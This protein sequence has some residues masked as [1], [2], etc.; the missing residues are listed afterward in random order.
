MFKPS[1]FSFSLGQL[2]ENTQNI[3]DLL[4]TRHSLLSK[5]ESTSSIDIDDEVRIF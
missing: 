2:K 1:F 3:I 5:L 4:K